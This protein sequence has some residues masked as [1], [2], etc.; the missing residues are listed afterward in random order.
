ML[1]LELEVVDTKVSELMDDLLEGDVWMRSMA[2]GR[3]VINFL[4]RRVGGGSGFVAASSTAFVVV[5][6]G[7]VTTF[8]TLLLTLAAFDCFGKKR[9]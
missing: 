6:V 4:R 1:I 5:V 7:V 2:D 8:A 9:G 3:D